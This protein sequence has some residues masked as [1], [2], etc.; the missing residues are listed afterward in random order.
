MVRF[1]LGLAAR[2]TVWWVI[3]IISLSAVSVGSTTS[4][5]ALFKQVFG[6]LPE[7]QYFRQSMG[8]VVDHQYVGNDIAVLVPSMGNDYKLFSYEL[9]TH[10]Y[11]IQR[12][13]TVRPLVK[14]IDDDGMILVKDMR[15]LGY[16]VIVNRRSFNVSIE[17]PATYRKKI[18]YYIM[19]EPEDVFIGTHQQVMPAKLSAYLNYSFSTN[20]VSSALDSSETGLEPP[21]GI[22]LGTAK[23]GTYSLN[24]AGA[25]DSGASS[26]L[27]LSNVNIAQ[28]LGEK[29][30]RI[31]VGQI[32][33]YTKGAQTGVSLM[34][35]SITRGPIL[36]TIGNF[37]PEF[38]YD[39]ELDVA[40]QIDIYINYHYVKT[41][42]LEGGMYELRGFPLRT[43]FNIVK[44]VKTSF[45]PVSSAKNL[46]TH[47]VMAYSR[48]QPNESGLTQSLAVHQERISQNDQKISK[49][50]PRKG[51]L[52]A[53]DFPPTQKKVVTQYVMPFAVDPVLYSPDY[54]EFNYGIGYP[55]SWQG[56]SPIISNE[57]T[58]SA[59]IKKGVNR[60]ITSTLYT[61]VN[62]QHGLVGNELYIASPVGPLSI[63]NAIKRTQGLHPL[64][65]QS[66]V[67]FLTYPI[68]SSPEQWFRLLSVGISYSLRTPEFISFG[69]ERPLI[70]DQLLTQYS[71]NMSY[72]LYRLFSGTIQYSKIQSIMGDGNETEQQLSMVVQR[73]LPW[74]FGVAVSYQRN[75]GANVIEP[76]L[77]SFQVSWS[78]LDGLTAANM[79]R[80]TVGTKDVQL[81]ATYQT[82]D[83]DRLL[84]TTT[85][86]H[87]SREKR[88]IST[89]L[90]YGRHNVGVSYSDASSQID[91]Q[92]N[93]TFMNQR[94][95]S[96]TGVLFRQIDQQ[97][98]TVWSMNAASSIVYAD[99]HWAISTPIQDNFA[100]FA[101]DNT[102]KDHTVFVGSDGRKIDGLGPT[103]I[104]SLRDR[105]VTDVIIDVPSLSVG[106]QLE[107]LYSFRPVNGQGYLVSLHV[108]PSVLLMSKLMGPN[109]QPLKYTKGYVSSPTDPENRQRFVTSRSGIFQ[110]A[111]LM[112]G[113]YNLTFANQQYRPITMNI[114]VGSDGLFKHP[115]VMVHYDETW[116]EKRQVLSETVVSESGGATAVS[117]VPQF[118]PNDLL[119][120][121]IVDI[122]A[123]PL[124]QIH[125]PVK[126]N[127]SVQPNIIELPSR[128]ETLISKF[129]GDKTTLQTAD[130]L[131][132][133]K[134]EVK[135]FVVTNNA[136]A[137]S[138]GSLE[139]AEKI[140]DYY[141]KKYTP[142]SKSLATKTSRRRTVTEQALL[143]HQH[144]Q[145]TSLRRRLSQ[146]PS[147]SSTAIDAAIQV[148]ETRRQSTQE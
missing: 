101:K 107:R 123:E 42:H 19:G 85:S 92:I 77:I 26:K 70:H 9:L 31:T 52:I 37:S 130:E 87:Q 112:P 144:R 86:L 115:P 53:D 30:Q 89:T 125:P 69:I 61:Q 40:S 11:D 17:V 3:F 94:F 56:V 45:Y 116:P 4:Y 143:T 59:Y 136:S 120:Q 6:R 131:H 36:D 55:L 50:I 88:N 146:T 108:T 60:L 99:H 29:N 47:N 81:D 133:L 135:S 134:Y 12:P 113:T 57:L 78:G 98:V 95:Q 73:K 68:Y 20:Y 114:P 141:L 96:N 142:K 90:K 79:Y 110:A 84:S 75:M 124:P 97:P 14:Y 27:N 15:Q 145:T 32:A 46:A 103:V 137:S 48:D 62:H 28:D 67:S 72:Q 129:S 25:F 93:Y 39:I 10:L 74:D 71:A 100:M 147:A 24:Y 80:Q 7:K 140:N 82:N 1:C 65:W 102:L 83:P 148:H 121:L 43:G 23:T 139:I 33:P 132:R 126:N 51:I 122:L 18:I 63:D 91:Q 13:G 119:Q 128:Q 64:G 8:L 5:D 2:F 34:G 35:A 66:R 21:I 54:T 104:P 105:V 109:N 138:M 106:A 76:E 58:H 111:N 127:M 118:T 22:F 38:F 44:L 16:S 117:S 41:V 49:K